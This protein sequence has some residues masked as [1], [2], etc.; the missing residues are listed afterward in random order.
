MASM[1]PARLFSSIGQFFLALA[2]PGTYW[3]VLRNTWFFLGAFFINEH[4]NRALGTRLPHDY[5]AS[6]LYGPWGART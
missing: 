3:L 2:A 5:G 6:P 1:A 4:L